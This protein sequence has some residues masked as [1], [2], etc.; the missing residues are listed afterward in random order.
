MPQ[1]I[2]VTY[3]P[4]QNGTYHM[5]IFYDKGDGSIPQ[6]IE[7]GPTIPYNGSSPQNLAL[8]EDLL[9]G[10]VELE[11][12]SV[13]MVERDGC[14]PADWWHREQSAERHC[15][16]RRSYRS[17]AGRGRPHVRGVDQHP[18]ALDLRRSVN[19]GANALAI[20]RAL[21]LIGA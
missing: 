14:S 16:S 5:A 8:A 2:G 13:E 6:I 4:V 9:L 1:T 12:R 20:A 10:S 19:R 15:S 7:V 21:V 11:G 18:A 3:L 17:G